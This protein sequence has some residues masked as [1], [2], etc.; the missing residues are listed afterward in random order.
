MTA[1]NG[2]KELLAEERDD[3]RKQLEEAQADSARNEDRAVKAYAAIKSEEKL[4][5]KARRRWNRAAASRG[6]PGGRRRA[7][8]S[9]KQAS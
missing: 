6:E 5:E 9:G 4:R 7:R 2:E 1:L 8:G 3:L